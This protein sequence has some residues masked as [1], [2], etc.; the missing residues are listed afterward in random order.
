LNGRHLA[1]TLVA[2]ALAVAACGGDDASEDSTRAADGTTAQP[3]DEA[4]STP[5]ESG[6]GRPYSKDAGNGDGGSS[7]AEAERAAGSDEAAPPRQRESADRKTKRRPAAPQTPQ[8]KIASLSPSERRHLHKDLYEQGKQLCY[9][10][11]P[12]ELAKN[13]NVP[14]TDPA[15]VARKYAELYERAAPTLIQPYQQGCLAGFRKFARNPPKNP[16]N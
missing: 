8:E 13:F 3:S 15:T 12:K 2:V 16:T 6:S 1:A 9:A 10:Y 4:Q 14:A 11:G 7:A 5:K